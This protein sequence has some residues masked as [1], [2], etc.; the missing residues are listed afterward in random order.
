MKRSFK[1]LFWSTLF[2]LIV[3]SSVT[4]PFLE[5]A[6]FGVQVGQV[7][8]EDAT[9]KISGYVEPDFNFDNPDLK[10]GFLVELVGYEKSALSDSAGYF[11]I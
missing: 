6:L 11:E 8:A 9:F 5:D 2:F 1:K 3:L 10:S 7:F 4:I